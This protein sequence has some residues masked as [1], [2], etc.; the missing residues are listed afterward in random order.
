LLD[1]IIYSKLNFHFLEPLITYK[2]IVIAKPVL[3]KPK[4]ESKKIKQKIKQPK[5]ESVASDLPT[6]LK[7]LVMECDP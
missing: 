5:P 4:V 3:N 2:E 7:L 1:E 6:N